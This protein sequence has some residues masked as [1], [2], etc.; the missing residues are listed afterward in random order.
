MARPTEVFKWA[1]LDTDGDGN[2]LKAFPPAEIYQTGLLKGE[3]WARLWHN[4]GF[5][6][7]SDWIQHLAGVS[8]D[9]GAEPIGTVKLVNNIVSIDASAIWGGTWVQRGTQTTGTITSKVFEKT[10]L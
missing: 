9:G 1:V 10:A 5:S 2:P 7:F 4:Q 8:S 3:P 6:N